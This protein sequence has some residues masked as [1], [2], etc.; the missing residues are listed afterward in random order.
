MTTTP[1]LVLPYLEAAK[2]QTHVTHNE[3]IRAF[4][5]INTLTMEV[6][7]SVG[8]GQWQAT[9]NLSIGL[10]PAQSV[11]LGVGG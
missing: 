2:A 7:Q 9:T 1:S 6:D 11:D 4:N 5:A 3:T 10:S 8:A